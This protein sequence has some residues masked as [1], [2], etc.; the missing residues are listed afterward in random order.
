VS[1]TPTLYAV[2]HS[3][4]AGQ[5]A[6][7][8][9][10]EQAGGGPL[11]PGY[12]Q[13][14]PL[15]VGGTLHLVAVD[16]AGRASAFE[17]RPSAGGFTPVDSQLVLGGPWD[18]IQPLVIGNVPH[19]LAYARAGQF[20]FYPITADLRSTTPFTY[21]RAHA[22]GLT[23]GFD[24]AQPVVVGGAVYYLCYG[25]DSGRVLIYS[26]SVTAE[27]S[28]DAPALASAPVWEHQWAPRWTRFAFFRL[29]GGV[30][31]LKTNVGR[32]NVNIDHIRDDP[33]RG[34]LEVGTHLD[35]E[36]A[37]KLDIVRALFLD[38]SEPYFLTYMKDG[39]TTFNR[40]HA[41]CAGWTTEARTASVT[42]ATQIVA[43]QHADGCY[44]LV[45]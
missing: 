2:R 38:R 37:L 39:T 28:G 33:A 40:I 9:V 18:L 23:S 11:A 12:T 14:V 29:G 34:T 31:F 6:V 42:D 35:L 5:L 15:V 44:V 17:V 36:N 13:L 19:L 1:P 43:L 10:W 7:E 22:P 16:G 20:S 21:A 8:P 45:Y 32:L 3:N 4:S 24:V 41:D 26:L 27:A 25:F 30:F